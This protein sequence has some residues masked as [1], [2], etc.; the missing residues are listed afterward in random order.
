MYVF[1]LS[2]IGAMF[3]GPRYGLERRNGRRGSAIGTTPAHTF[4]TSIVIGGSARLWVLSSSARP[5]RVA[6][7]TEQYL[8]AIGIKRDSFSVPS[9]VFGS[10]SL[11]LYD[12]SDSA[13]LG[14]ASADA[15]PVPPMPTDPRPGCRPWTQPSPLDDFGHTVTAQSQ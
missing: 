6:R 10:V 14:A 7:P 5:Y 15:F 1:P 2:R 9:L 8:S 4:A 11:E 3:Y 13:R 12:L